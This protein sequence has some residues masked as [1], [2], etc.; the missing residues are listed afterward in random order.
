MI[1][2]E[3]SVD[4]Y[5]HDSC[6]H[7][8]LCAVVHLAQLSVISI[9]HQIFHMLLKEKSDSTFHDYVLVAASAL[10]Q[11]NCTSNKNTVHRDAKC[12]LFKIVSQE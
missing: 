7:N 8:T 12:S 1:F 2:T 4:V 9:Q 10:H 5:K 3:Q 11:S 6:H